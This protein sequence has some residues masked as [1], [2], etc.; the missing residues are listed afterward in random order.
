MFIKRQHGVSLIEI[1][2][3]LVIVSVG[4]AGMLSTFQAT[5]LR[6]ADPLIQ[7]QMLAIAESLLDEILARDFAPGDD[8][9][10]PTDKA[11]A[12]FRVE[13]AQYDDVSDY[14]GV[15]DCPVYSLSD[16]AV[17]P[18][19]EA[20]RIS[21]AA[22]NADGLNGLNSVDARKVVVTVRQ[23]DQSLTMEGWRTNY[24]S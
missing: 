6:S 20:Y 23:A 18:G 7:K 10:A 19:L 13:R 5:V 12:T 17:V 11:C 9:F 22:A 1:L 24:G 4:L 21:I 2:I 8:S 3:F 16:N 14:D 15:S